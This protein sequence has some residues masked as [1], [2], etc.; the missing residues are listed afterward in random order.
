VT[1]IEDTSL[2]HKLK[3]MANN[4]LSFA[5]APYGEAQ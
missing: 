1:F 2:G 4:Y 5:G 3:K